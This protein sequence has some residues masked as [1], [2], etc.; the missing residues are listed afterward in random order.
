[1]TAVKNFYAVLGVPRNATDAEIKKA[2]RKLARKYHPDLNPDDANAEAKMRELNKAYDVLG[3]PNVRKS[4]DETICPTP[5]PSPGTQSSQ[6][7]SDS[8][9]W[10]NYYKILGV[11]RNANGNAINE[12]Y[13]RR[14]S[15]CRDENERADINDA[16]STLGD[17][18]K[19]AGYDF[20][21]DVIF[22]N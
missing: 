11:P 6:K 3:N 13:R 5:R 4:Y 17:P 7:K 14:L 1:M 9:T 8:V 22:R 16:Y 2:Y 21:Y 10:K 15:N 18:A 12:A 19:R 20:F